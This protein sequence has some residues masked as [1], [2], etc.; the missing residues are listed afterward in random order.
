M[1]AVRVSWRLLMGAEALPGLVMFL[2][3]LKCAESPHWLLRAGAACVLVAAGT[4]VDDERALQD[5]VLL[6]MVNEA[7]QC[8]QD[9]VLDNPVDGDI[10][11][12]FGLGFPPMRGG[13]F[14]RRGGIG[15]VGRIRSA[16]GASTHWELYHRAGGGGVAPLRVCR[17]RE[18]DCDL[19]S[20]LQSLAAAAHTR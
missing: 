4:K 8:L 6:R 18:W 17:G 12:V 15:S 14:R 10:G 7:V 16:R 9:G 11:A 5:R 13:P 3:A 2:G 1:K 20:P 19:R